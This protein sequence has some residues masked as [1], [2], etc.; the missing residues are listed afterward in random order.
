[1]VRRA[2]KRNLKIRSEAAAAMTTAAGFTVPGSGPADFPGPTLELMSWVGF[3]PGV[4]LLI[5]GWI[6]AT[7]RC[8]WRSTTGEIFESGL[9]KGLRW[10]DNE[11][12][13]RLSLIPADDAQERKS[14]GSSTASTLALTELRRPLL[15]HAGGKTPPWRGRVPRHRQV[16]L[17]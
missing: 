1:M 6:I 16:V 9:Y 11:D 3:V 2:E 5:W 17:C 7:R 8:P 12:L 14:S 4:P 13:P 15:R 10:T